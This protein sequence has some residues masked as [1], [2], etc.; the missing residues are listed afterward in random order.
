MDKN[1]TYGIYFSWKDIEKIVE[2]QLGWVEVVE[3]QVFCVTDLMNDHAPIG[4]SIAVRVDGIACENDS[5]V[6]KLS[7]SNG[8]YSMQVKTHQKNDAFELRFDHAISVSG[9]YGCIVD[10]VLDILTNEEKEFQKMVDD[11]LGYRGDEYANR[12]RMLNARYPGDR[13]LRLLERI[14]TEIR[15][16]QVLIDEAVSPAQLV[17]AFIEMTERYVESCENIEKL[18]PQY[19]ELSKE[20]EKVMNEG[21]RYAKKLARDIEIL[22]RKLNSNR[23]VADYC[24][25]NI[26][27]AIMPMLALN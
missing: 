4:T 22:N 14:R 27:A 5:N 25:A 15:A 19:D 17:S 3:D 6:L 18:K 20:Y 26:E 8:I 7:L 16:N 10:G 13:S 24:L 2:E 21:G 9:T 23:S 11:Q 1:N 12:F